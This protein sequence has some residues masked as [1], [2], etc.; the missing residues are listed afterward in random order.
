MLRKALLILAAVGL[1][2][3]CAP[4]VILL[5]GWMR[6]ERL[7]RQIVEK[8]DQYYLT[9]TTPGR[10]EY[11]L[12]GDEV[13]EVPYM[14]STLSV[15]AEPTRIYDRKGKL[16]GEYVAER[17]LYVRSENDLPVFLKKAL[18]A[19][20]DRTFYEHR[21]VNIRAIGRAM[22]ANLLAGR[23]KQGGSTLTQQLAKVLFTTRR[24]T[25]SRKSFELFCARRLEEKFTKDQL[26]LMYLNFVYFG[27][28]CYG[29]ECA[30]RFYFDKPTRSL[31]LGE[32]A[33]LAGIIASPNNYS[34]FKNLDL[35][36][37]RQRT[38]L[39]RMAGAGYIPEGAAERYAEE[40]WRRKGAKLGAPEDSFWRM[41]VNRAP[42]FVEHVRRELARRYPKD[43]ILK[44]GLRIH[45]TLDLDVQ[46]AAKRALGDG[47]AEENRRYRVK[48]PSATT[49]IEGGL[50]AVDLSDG[51]VLALVGGSAFSFQNQ[52]DRA[53]G[54][55]RPF[56]SAIKP[57]V[58]AAAF[59]SGEF[60][61]EDTMTDELSSYKRGP[62]ERWAPRNYTGKY[63]G[64]VTLETALRKSLN[65]VAVRLLSRIDI[66]DVIRL[67]SEATGAPRSN[68]PRNL[69]LA[70]GSPGLTPLEAASAYAIFGNGGR[71]VRPYSIARI[72]DR[73]GKLLEEHEPENLEPILSTA[74][75]AAM[76]RVLEGVLKP[77]G[78]AAWAARRT[79]FGLPAA[80]KTGTTD[81]YRDAW[82]AGLTPD[83][84]AAVRVGHDDMRLP[85]GRGRSGG[86]VAAPI[87]MR[88]VKGVYR[89]RPTRPFHRH[90]AN[91]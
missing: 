42:Y 33:L 60:S 37:A 44:G 43:R 77:G 27:H 52:L 65:T 13:F 3:L 49:R 89:N 35:A 81:D 59:D 21:G 15:A 86:M 88:F 46:R 82:F 57:F 68:F 38:V 20:E 32:A 58:Y 87:W 63:Y 51:G 72:E 24:K 9:I 84:A 76:L 90:E 91:R 11:L 78:T 64:E 14:A 40:F 8:M 53:A 12:S 62:G 47:L 74:T 55:R 18:V 5:S 69:A 71:P 30:S 31:E 28:G 1:A 4:A 75:C 17:S 10:E 39:R 34:P 2:A 73:N 54:G 45:T 41:N 83:L 25:F 80:G 36:K 26:L 67:L 70:L 66:D 22:A 50:A 85:L 29:I 56:G 61:P 16:I 79:G 48:H 19:T 7:E 6:F 23:K